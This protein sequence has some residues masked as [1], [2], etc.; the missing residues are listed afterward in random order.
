MKARIVRIEGLCAGCFA[1]LDGFA[2]EVGDLREPNTSTAHVCEKCAIEVGDLGKSMRAKVDDLL[3]E[4]L[5]ER[6]KALPAPTEEEKREQAASFAFGNL[7]L[8]SRCSEATP[9]EL[10]ALRARC[11]KAAGCDDHPASARGAKCAECGRP[12]VLG[13]WWPRHPFK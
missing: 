6:A 9:E 3:L 7:A 1:D 11:R 10:E 13:V 12:H 8:S 4:S 5:L 2:I